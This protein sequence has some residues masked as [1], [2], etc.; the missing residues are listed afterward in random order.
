MSDIVKKK[1]GRKPKNF[2][3]DLETQV[4]LPVVSETNEKKKRGRKKK[5]EI[6]NFKKINN[7]EQL[8]NF[9]HHIAY[10]DDDDPIETDNVK[11]VSFGN[12][13]ITVVK[14]NSTDQENFRNKFSIPTPKPTPNSNLILNPEVNETNS[15]INENEYSSDEE[16]EIP[17]ENILSLNQE[18]FEK[19]YKENKKYVTD[20][21]ETIKDQS[22]KRIRVI[23]T[24]KNVITESEWPEK[25][26]SCCWWCC[27]PFECSPC[28]LPY[29]YDSLRKRFY[30]IGV[31]CSWSCTK[32][33]NF[34]RNDHKKYERSG[35]ITLLIQQLYGITK[36]IA[37]K[38]APPRQ[39]L[40]MFG[41]Y[42]NITEF[43]NT[44][45]VVDAFKINQLNFNFTHPE[46]TEVT[47]VKIKKEKKDLRLTRK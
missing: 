18:N 24:L 16:K 44:D 14:K 34:E 12:L 8:N 11:K 22:L 32:S 38:T 39:S 27:H 46:I 47:N 41:G 36:A 4:S 17:I 43:R 28:T 30:F 15:V 23:S 3:T 9:N 29:K 33:Y 10:S 19:Y 35:L 25:V 7:R 6:E 13:D 5:Y 21:S 37:I 31:F 1:R 20:F 40:K 2:Y 26:E 42:M 45:S